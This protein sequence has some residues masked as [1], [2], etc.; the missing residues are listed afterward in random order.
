MWDDAGGGCNV[1]VPNLPPDAL[2]DGP[3]ASQYTPAQPGEIG[4]YHVTGAARIVPHP[5]L[6]I[7]VSDFRK[8]KCTTH[9][10]FREYVVYHTR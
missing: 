4:D 7:S 2:A 9:K 10:N 5:F 6:G 8:F 3:R 1:A